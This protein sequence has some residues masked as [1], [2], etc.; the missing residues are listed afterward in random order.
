MEQCLYSIQT[1]LP[2]QI[3]TDRTPWKNTE[4]I[5]GKGHN[6]REAHTA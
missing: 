3:N 5:T 2:Q 4:N 1:L 6:K